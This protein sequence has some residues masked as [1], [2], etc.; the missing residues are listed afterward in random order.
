MAEGCPTHSG[1]HTVVSHLLVTGY[2]PRM[3][4]I[5]VDRGRAAL[6]DRG[7]QLIDVLPESVLPAGAPAR[8]RSI[9]P[10]QTM[11]RDCGGPTWIPTAPSS[12]TAFDQH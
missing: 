2:T 9:R 8:E 3:K 6:I 11:D 10:L 7:A 4:R 5:D 1:F 12:C